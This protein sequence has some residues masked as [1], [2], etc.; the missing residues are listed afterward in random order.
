[1]RTFTLETLLDTIEKNNV[2][3]GGL[4]KVFREFLDK[5]TKVEIVENLTSG[6]VK[7]HGLYDSK[8]NTIKIDKD[9]LIRNPNLEGEDTKHILEEFIHSLT[10]K[11]LDKYLKIRFFEKNNKVT[12]S[13]E[14]AKD[15][16]SSVIRLARIYNEAF[17]KL[18]TKKG[19][20]QFLLDYLSKRQKNK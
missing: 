17:N 2:K 16:P 1:M 13:A 6:N 10:K 3:Y 4:V 14:V 9:L 11:D 5:E 19:G 8:T 18:L 7:A 12:M 15:A 20:S